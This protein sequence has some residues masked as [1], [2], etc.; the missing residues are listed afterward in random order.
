VPRWP[1]R[2]AAKLNLDRFDF[3]PN[4]SQARALNRRMRLSLADSLQHV[5]DQSAGHLPFD[6]SALAPLIL[7][8]RS[9]ERYPCSTFAIYA[10][11]VL[12]IC[13]GEHNRAALLLE[14]I[15]LEKPLAQAWR[16]LA[17][18]D[19]V[20]EKNMNRYLLS[21]NNES[22]TDFFMGSP[23]ADLADRFGQRV[24]AGYSLLANEIPEL[25]AEFDEL[26]SD[27]IMVVGD[28]KAKYQ[29]DG[30]S[31]YFLWGGLFLNATS[32]ETE[33]AMAE[34]MAH[35]SAHILLYACAA[36]E[37]LVK[38]PD[39]DLFPSPL[40]TDLRPMDGIY[41][42][43]FVSARMH[44]AMAQLISSGRLSDS[45]VVAAEAARLEDSKNFWAGH[46]LVARHGQL[47]RTGA[48]VMQGALSYMESVR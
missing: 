23:S 35:E 46:E 11:I 47:T 34:V 1:I 27:V 4:G 26:V 6:F 40:R 2:P 44:W 24:R 48:E 7:S 28:D 15:A 12:A 39:E 22:D 33:V 37:A 32:H 31:S 8:I 42:A 16:V 30:G 14:E 21:M 5:S 38:N 36:D 19:P 43:T 20:H 29:F 17:I 3:F 18:D 41:H 10:E 25:A 45:A 9:G 13:N